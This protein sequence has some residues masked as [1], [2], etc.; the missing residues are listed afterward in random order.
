MT[1]GDD[2]IALAGKLFAGTSR[3][4]AILRTVVSRSYYGAYHST[5]DFLIELG[6]KR[7]HQHNF[8]LD[9]IESGQPDAKIAGKLLGDL[10]SKRRLADYE[11]N[12]VRAEESKFTELSVEQAREVQSL[13]SKIRQEPARSAVK[14]GIEAYRQRIGPRSSS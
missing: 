4:S 2:F 1:T 7:S 3:S 5:G 11:L 12:D 6:I 13:L 9:L 10:L 14:V 8:H